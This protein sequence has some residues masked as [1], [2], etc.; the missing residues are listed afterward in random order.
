MTDLVQIRRSSSTQVSL[1]DLQDRLD[2]RQQVAETRPPATSTK[3]ARIEEAQRA[4]DLDPLETM[5]QIQDIASDLADVFDGEITLGSIPLSQAQKNKLSAEWLRVERLQAQLSAL[6]TRYR[7]LVFA[8]LDETGPK[9]PGR[10]AAQVPGKVE[11]QGPGPHYIFERRGGN[12]KDPDLD[13]VGLRD[14]LPDDIAAQVYLTV[15]HEAVYAPAYDEEVFDEGTFGR[16]VDE[17]KIDLDVV[18]PFLTP[19]PWRTPAFYKTL[20]DGEK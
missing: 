13:A 14:V 5:V 15:H 7:S 1:A 10:P 19:G 3:K 12:R 2:A 17:G 6:E 8:H 9:I 18:A 20:V 4:F 11:A 16:L